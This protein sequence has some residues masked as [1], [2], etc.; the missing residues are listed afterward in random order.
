MLESCKA[1]FGLFEEIHYIKAKV[2][3]QENEI[4]KYSIILS[5]AYVLCSR[6]RAKV[7]TGYNYRL[8]MLFHDV[9]SMICVSVL[10]VS[11]W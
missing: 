5:L 3:V 4:L 11:F 2:Y 10:K 1:S 9:P 8:S 7:W 6:T